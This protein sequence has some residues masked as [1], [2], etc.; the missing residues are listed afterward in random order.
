MSKT[1]DIGEATTNGDYRLGDRYTYVQTNPYEDHDTKTKTGE[2]IQ[3]RFMQKRRM[4]A[5]SKSRKLS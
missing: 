5:P 4:I 1:A 3:S 2:F